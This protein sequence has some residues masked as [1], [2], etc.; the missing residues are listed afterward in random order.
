MHTPE[1][2]KYVSI[3]LGSPAS[4][5]KEEDYYETL[6]ASVSIQLG[7]PASGDEDGK[8]ASLAEE[9]EFPFN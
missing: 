7:S 8:R 3:Q 5:D 6:L 4:G 9:I 2:P 1:D